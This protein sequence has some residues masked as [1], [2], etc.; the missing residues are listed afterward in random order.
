MGLLSSRWCWLSVCFL[1]AGCSAQV[2]APCSSSRPQIELLINSPTSTWQTPHFS[3]TALPVSQILLIWQN[4]KI[5]Q[6]PAIFRSACL[7]S[8]MA[9]ER[10][11]AMGS[12][13]LGWVPSTCQLVFLHP[14][15]CPRSWPSFWGYC[16]GTGLRD[17]GLPG[18]RIFMSRSR[19]VLWDSCG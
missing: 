12:G 11:R 3:I 1:R 4:P 16:A 6:S 9:C 2:P 15:S 7:W 14:R 8:P 18:F 10:E 5:K 19:S 13:C 17:P